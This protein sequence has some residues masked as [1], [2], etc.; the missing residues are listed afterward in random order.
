MASLTTMHCHFRSEALGMDTDVNVLIPDINATDLPVLYL[1]HGMHG[2]YTSWL[3]GSAIGRYARMRKIAVVMPSALNSFY[4]NMKYG[5]RYYDYITKDLPEFLRA[6]FPMLSVK[7]EKTFIA[8]LSMGGYGAVKLALRN[9][10]RFSA[11]ASLSGCLDLAGRIGGEGVK[12]KDVAIANWGESYEQVF[13]GSDDDLFALVERFPSHQPKPRIFYVCGTED[14]LYG[15]NQSFRA[16]IADKGFETHYDESEGV[17]DWVFWD[18][19]IL[20]AIDYLM[21]DL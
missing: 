5:Y 9:P 4:T 6:A 15:E 13:R 10:D 11:C 2:D 20:P 7:R 8:G 17:H 18:R 12:W 3:N 14:Y 21:R 16:F 19:W 1:L